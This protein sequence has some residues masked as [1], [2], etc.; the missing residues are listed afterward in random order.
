MT[1]WSATEKSD[2]IDFLEWSYKP[3]CVLT[4]SDDNK[5]LFL[6]NEPDSGCSIRYLKD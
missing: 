6:Q 2:K 1:W 3:I 4:I 5:T